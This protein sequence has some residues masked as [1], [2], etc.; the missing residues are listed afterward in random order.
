VEENSKSINE[1]NSILLSR[2]SPIAFVVGAAGFLGSSLID[3]LLSKNIQVVGVDDLSSGKKENLEE[4]SKNKKFHFIN[5]S[6][7]DQ[8]LTEMVS[9]PRLDYAFFVAESGEKSLYSSGLLNFLNFVLESKKNGQSEDSKHHPRVVLASSIELY[10]KNFDQNKQNLKDGE[11]RFARFIK[12][13]KLNGR[14]VR[15]SAVFG[16][17]MHFREQDPQVRLIQA[18]LADVLHDTPTSADFSSRAIFIGDATS[19]LIK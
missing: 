10:G 6:I 14:I 19:L 7:I 8:S 17:R 5:K 9:L 15:L 16:P 13:H 1:K 4:A 3:E 2:N 11:I 18:S 12:Y